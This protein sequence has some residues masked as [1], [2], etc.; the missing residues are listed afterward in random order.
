MKPKKA[1][2]PNRDDR[3]TIAYTT[4]T[5]ANGYMSDYEFNGWKEEHK[6]VNLFDARNF[7]PC[8]HACSV[9]LVILND[10]RRSY[11][12]VEDDGIIHELIHILHIPLIQEVTS[13]DIE[14]HMQ[15]PSMQTLRER[16]LKLQEDA[17][18][19]YERIYKEQHPDEYPQQLNS[20]YRK[21]YD[22]LSL[23][24]SPQIQP[25]ED[26]G[27][28][29]LKTREQKEGGS[30]KIEFAPGV[31]IFRPFVPIHQPVLQRSWKKE[32][33]DPSGLGEA[34]RPNDVRAGDAG[35]VS[36]HSLQQTGKVWT[37]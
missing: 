20:F 8:L 3:P 32:A 21:G 1:F 7:I 6:P 2:R 27:F 22:Y 29:V 19:E 12:A 33:S 14:T 16:I 28:K 25:Y 30:F 10:H 11:E 24:I 9:A 5:R 4:D 36:M 37:K 13:R 35:Q 15:S 31:E 17:L 18:G 34:E 23:P 26:Y